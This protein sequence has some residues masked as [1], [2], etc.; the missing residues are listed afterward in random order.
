MQRRRLPGMRRIAL[1]A[2]DPPV[3]RLITGAGVPFG[4][5]VYTGCLSLRHFS[6]DGYSRRGRAEDRRALRKSKASRLG[7]RWF[8][9]ELP[10][11]KRYRIDLA[12]RY[13][14]K[15]A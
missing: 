4:P 15:A 2:P 11:K 9:G 12:I 13:L 6:S 10:N 7:V 1:P 14:W 3:L 8:T 5:I